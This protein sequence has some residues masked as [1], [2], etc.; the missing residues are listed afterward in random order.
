ML[1]RRPTTPR[2]TRSPRTASSCS[3]RWASSASRPARSSS[4]RRSPRRRVRLGPHRRHRRR[5]SCASR[6]KMVGVV[7]AAFGSGERD[8]NG[9]I[10]VVGVGRIGGEVAAL[11]I[12]ADEG[13]NWLK[14]AQLVLLI[15]VAQPRA[16][17]LQPRPAAAARRRPRRRRDVGGDQAGLGQAAAPPRPRL[18]RRRQGAAHRLRH[19]ARA[20]HMSVCS[21]TPTSSSRSTSSADAR[22]AAIRS[23]AGRRR[24][25]TSRHEA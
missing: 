2:A 19:V 3:H 16:L 23:A 7:Q 6:E 4:R 21:S 20:H 15:A 12:P 25:R 18:R 14:I 17:R 24:L 22:T 5:S 11:D 1:D 9:P 13:G 8:P 10:C